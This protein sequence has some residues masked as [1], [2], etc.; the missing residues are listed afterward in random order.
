MKSEGYIYAKA[1]REIHFTISQSRFNAAK[2]F[3]NSRKDLDFKYLSN[4]WGTINLPFLVPLETKKMEV[5][6]TP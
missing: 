5:N 2:H 3:I 1:D 4:I 6:V